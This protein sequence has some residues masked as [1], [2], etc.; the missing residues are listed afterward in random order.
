MKFTWRRAGASIA[1]LSLAL[2]CAPLFAQARDEGPLRLSLAEAVDIAIANNLGLESARISASMARRASDLSWNQFIPSLDLSGTA[3]RLNN[4][5]AINIPGTATPLPGARSPQWAMTGTF[6]TA[7]N[8]NVSMFEDMRR[9]RLEYERGLISYATATAQLERDTR[10]AFHNIL[11]LQ[12]NIALLHGSFENASRQAQISQANFN[13]GLAP[14]L[15]LLQAQV[16]RENLRPIID[17]AESGLRLLIMQFAVFLGLPYDTE[18]ELEP[19]PTAMAPMELDAAALIARA[20]AAQPGA[21]ATRQDILVLE[22]RLRAGRLRLY[23]PSLALNWS[24]NSTYAGNRW[25][26]NSWFD[27]IA[28]NDNWNRGGSLS[29]T[30][31]FRL[32]GLLPFGLERQ[33]LAALA[34]Q[35][36]LARIGLAQMIRGTE[37]EIHNLVLTLERTRLTAGALAQTAALAQRSF[38]LTEQAH[39]AGLAD[40][41]QVQNAEQSLRQAQVQLHEQHYNYLNGLIDLEYALGVPFGTLILGGDFNEGSDD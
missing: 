4:P 8:L 13:A 22:S 29:I 33:G 35:I 3:S 25:E 30:L 40:L 34:D 7:L 5:P 19:V 12:E 38:E 28:D 9:L 21:Q 16:A 32:N 14:E 41:F 6:S 10:K 1:A 24:L 20:A 36:S 23:T 15:T 11:Y 26:E 31:A 18:F 2:L 37:I 17:Q 39:R 27:G